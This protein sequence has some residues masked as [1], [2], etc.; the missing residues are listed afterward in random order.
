MRCGICGSRDLKEIELPFT[1]TD[2]EGR[3]HLRINKG[4]GDYARCQQCGNIKNVVKGESFIGWKNVERI[5]KKPMDALITKVG[6]E[7][8]Y[9]F[10]TVIGKGITITIMNDKKEY[11]WNEGDVIDLKEYTKKSNA[12][13]TRHATG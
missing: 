7:K 8:R 1:K 12:C 3:V 9:Y 13:E 5:T 11:D 4:D 6:D 2:S 10:A